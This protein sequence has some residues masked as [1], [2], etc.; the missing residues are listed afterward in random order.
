MDGEVTLDVL[1]L[2]PIEGMK[3]GLGGQ[4]FAKS[5]DKSTLENGT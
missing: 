3:T 1:K 4:L 5:L 2:S